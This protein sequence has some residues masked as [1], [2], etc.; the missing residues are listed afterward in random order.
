LIPQMASY[1]GFN[2]FSLHSLR[3]KNKKDSLSPFLFLWVV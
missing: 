3:K 1:F 2:P